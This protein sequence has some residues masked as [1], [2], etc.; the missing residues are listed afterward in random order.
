MLTLSARVSRGPN[1]GRPLVLARNRGGRF[2][3]A[4][5]KYADARLEHAS[6]DS[7]ARAV[8]AEGH[9]AWFSGDGRGGH[10]AFHKPRR[11]T[12]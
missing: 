6:E 10:A 12:R 9:G 2:M 4:P 7:A 5:F 3:T 11:R 1:K 8:Y